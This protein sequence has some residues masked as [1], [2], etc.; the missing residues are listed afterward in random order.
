MTRIFNKKSEQEKRRMLRAAATTAEKIMWSYLRKHQISDTRFLRQY[1]INRFVVDFYSPELKLAIEI[2]GN[3]HTGKEEYDK[4]RQEIIENLNIRFLRFTND[5]VLYNPGNVIDTIT[6]FI[7]E[8][9]EKG[10]I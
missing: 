4:L 10:Q 8:A 6:G 5:E 9:G 2:D 1:S 7:K 3:S